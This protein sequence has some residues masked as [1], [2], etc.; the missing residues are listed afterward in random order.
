MVHDFRIWEVSNWQIDEEDDRILR[1]NQRGGES[2]LELKII[3]KELTH[4]IYNPKMWVAF[5]V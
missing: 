1:Q 5:V 3:I 2:K 4:S